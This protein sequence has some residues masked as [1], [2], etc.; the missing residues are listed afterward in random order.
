MGEPKQ[1]KRL[2]GLKKSVVK[3]DVRLQVYSAMVQP[4]DQALQMRGMLKLF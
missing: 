4:M 1:V 2:K 3:S